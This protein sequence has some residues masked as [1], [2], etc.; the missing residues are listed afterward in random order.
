MIPKIVYYCWFGK[1]KPAA[2]EERIAK[3]Q[4]K[5]DTYELIEINEMNFDYNQF[6]FT[7]KA[8]QAGQFAYVSDVARLFYLR[9]TGG[10]YL[11]TDV[12]VVADFDAFL[13]TDMMHVSME[14][15]GFE[16]TGVNV[17]TIIAPAHHPVIER[18]YDAVIHSVY[19]ETRA[20]INTYFND[21][22]A[23]FSYRN[24][25]QY[26]PLL[27]TKLHP[28]HVFCTASK[29]SVTIHR[30]D[31]SWGQKLTVRQKIKR[32]IGVMIKKCIGRKRYANWFQRRK[33]S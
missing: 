7:Q 6:E 28:T 19:T 32:F 8:Y 18:V 24:K 21:V 3:W 5:L 15:Y 20:T 17:G 22:L 16:I 30:Y 2:I 29:K 1:A 33:E 14:Y 12:D 31:N 4:K 25:M 23:P 9:E 26:L 10:I 11:D 13:N 27:Q